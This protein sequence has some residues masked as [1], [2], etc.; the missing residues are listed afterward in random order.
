MHGQLNLFNFRLIS[1]AFNALY[2]HS[3]PSSDANTETTST[4]GYNKQTRDFDLAHSLT[5]LAS[6]P[7][8]PTIQFAYCKLSKTGRWEGLGTRLWFVIHP[9]KPQAS[10]LARN[11]GESSVL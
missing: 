11:Q 3:C 4:S 10:F 1:H 5:H 2:L 6:F 8:L 9:L 7:G